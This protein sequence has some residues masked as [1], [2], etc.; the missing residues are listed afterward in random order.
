MLHEIWNHLNPAFKPN[1]LRFYRMS[2]RILPPRN[3]SIE[4]TD[5][6]NLHCPMCPRNFAEVAGESLSL[7][8]FKYILNQ[9]PKV[10]Q[11]T[12][13]GRGE[14]LMAPDFFEMLN[15]G[16]SRNINFTVVTNGTLLYEENIRKLNNVSKVVVSIDSPYPEKYKKIRG[17][18]LEVIIKNLKKL[19]QLKKEIHLCIQ[20]LIMEDNIKDLPEFITLAQNAHADEVILIHLIGFDQGLD[21]KHGDNFKNINTSLQK[22]KELAEENGIKLTA[23]PLCQEPRLCVEPWTSPRISLRGDIYP[24]CYI[25]ETSESIWQEW[26]RGVCLSVPQH[27]YKIGNIFEE[28]FKKLWNGSDYRILRGTVRK[29]ETRILLSPKEINKQREEV[30]LEEKF[31][32]CKNCLYR[33]NRA[34]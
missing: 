10:K 3:F 12:L 7:E 9:L 15:C 27:Q 5:D 14:T 33:Q 19:K 18:N 1:L 20:A 24:C 4:V 16:N 30:N 29:F 28:S 8:K 13:L 31:S 26:Y 34:C 11:I 25:Y 6:C 17:A 21:K 23:T 32:Y 2:N 22:A